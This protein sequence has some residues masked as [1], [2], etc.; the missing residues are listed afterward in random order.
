MTLVLGGGR[1]RA[2]TS[3]IG[4]DVVS[5]VTPTFTAWGAVEKPEQEHEK[6]CPKKDN[7]GVQCQGNQIDKYFKTERN[8]PQS[9][10]LSIK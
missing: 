9:Q 6:E 7:Q 5:W 3:G 8:K 1:E 10:L 2:Y 4:P